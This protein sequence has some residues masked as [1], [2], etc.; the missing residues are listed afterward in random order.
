MK[1]LITFLTFLL[2]FFGM[3]LAQAYVV[4]VY[5]DLKPASQAML[6]YQRI[7]TPVLANTTRL[8]ALTATSATLTTTISTFVAQ[9]D[10]PRNIT[11]TTGGTT[12]DCKAANVTVSGTNFYG[13]AISEA[14]AIADN[15]AGSTSGAKAFKTVTSVSIPAQDGA[16]CT[17]SV[18]VGDVLG[19]KSCMKQAGD[20]A[21]AVFDG[22]YEATRPTCLA[23]ASHV[24]SNTCDINGTL[25]GSKN[26]DLYYVQ[27]FACHP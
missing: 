2:V 22:A 15:Q 8:K 1:M 16:G 6:E 5:R 11:V 9:P 25:N 26:V 10:V 18:G 24:E 21:W 20:V 23:D 27:N 17:Y 7:A 12:A 19:L 14:L 3:S 13:A 4:P